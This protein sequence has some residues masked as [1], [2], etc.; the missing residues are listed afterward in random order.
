MIDKCREG[1]K[2][3]RERT[4]YYKEVCTTDKAFLQ[5]VQNVGYLSEQDARDY[6]AVG[7]TSRGSNVPYDV[8]HSF[9][10][11]A[12]DEV[13]VEPITSDLGDVFGRTVVRVLEVIQAI[14]LSEELLDRLPDG[15]IQVRAKPR[16]PEGETVCRCEAPRGELIYYM[17]SD[18]SDKPARVKVRT[19]SLANWPATIIMLK[20][21]FVADAPIIIASIDPCMSCTDR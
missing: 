5:R 3:L 4:E 11:D 13:K 17:R 19:P 12:Y 16:V 9:P 14:D 15:D 8:R 7:P 20:G 1:L 18:G 21:C 10:Y 2:I 6:G